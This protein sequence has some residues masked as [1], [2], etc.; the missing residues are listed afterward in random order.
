MFKLV[1]IPLK[2]QIIIILNNLLV[3]TTD[4][5]RRLFYLKI[6]MTKSVL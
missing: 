6:M 5:V 1:T 3:L 2:K 4:H